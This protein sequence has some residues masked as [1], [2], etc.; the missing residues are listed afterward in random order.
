L[1]FGEFG[2][3]FV[4]SC[5]LLPH[6]LR[7]MTEACSEFL[8]KAAD[9]CLICSTTKKETLDLIEESHLTIL[10]DF[11]DSLKPFLDSKKLQYLT[12]KDGQIFAEFF[13]SRK[14]ILKRVLP[15]RSNV[16]NEILAATE[17]YVASR[18][19]SL[20]TAQK[21]TPDDFLASMITELTRIKHELKQP[22]LSLREV[23]IEPNDSIISLIAICTIITNSKDI[24]H[25]ASVLEYQF[26]E[27]QWIIFVTTDESEILNKQEELYT[28]FR[29]RCSKPDWAF[30]YYR[31]ITKNIPPVEHYRKLANY[32]RHQK[33]FGRI[34]EK[35][36]DINVLG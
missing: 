13:V 16:P 31:E 36:I 33:D 24:A 30:D 8:E 17:R 22:L 14:K 5:I 32:T 15:R 11:R 29:L 34:I 7:G 26:R 12:N 6:P 21:I 3:Y 28:I 9:S 20:K 1:T 2:G 4:D 35:V 25:L 18:L 19:H 27:N 10:V 23:E